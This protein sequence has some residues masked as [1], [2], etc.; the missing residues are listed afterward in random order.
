MA[1]LKKGIVQVYTGEGKGKTSAALGLALRAIGRDLKVVFIQFMKE[2]E[3]GTGELIA[4]RTLLP[5][6]TV[7]Q[8]GSN[9]LGGITPERFEQVKTKVDEGMAFARDTVAR[10]ACDVLVL[11]EVG[12]AIGYNLLM[13]DDLVHFIEDKPADMEL[14]LTGHEMPGEILDRADLV[15]EM[16]NIKHPLETGLKAREGIE[17]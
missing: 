17:Y 15:T 16:I 9:F 11:D 4:A 7:L 8:F 2:S 1:H 10:Q 14:I 6:M 12:S 3:Q 5:T 13:I